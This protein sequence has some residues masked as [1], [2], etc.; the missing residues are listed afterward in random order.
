[1]S[2]TFTDAWSSTS[3]LGGNFGDKIGSE[4]DREFRAAGGDEQVVVQLTSSFI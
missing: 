4:G 1:M 3:S 2:T